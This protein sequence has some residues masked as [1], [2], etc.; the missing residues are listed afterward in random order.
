MKLV[1]R[2]IYTDFLYSEFRAHSSNVFSLKTTLI[3]QNCDAGIAQLTNGL[4]GKTFSRIR[5][6][7]QITCFN[8]SSMS[9]CMLSM[10]FVYVK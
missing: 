8:V 4:A 7:V 9:L 6:V 10:C 3:L 1:V 2:E 5:C